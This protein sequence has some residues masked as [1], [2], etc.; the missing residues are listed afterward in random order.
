MDQKLI[1]SLLE[2]PAYP[3]PTAAV[4]LV[5][6]HVS[7]IFI[8]DHFVYKVKKA[9][10]YG[11]LDFT[12][13]DRRRF[14]CGEEVR[15][16]R[17]LCPDVYL[18]VVELRQSGDGAAF[19]GSGKVIDYAVKMKRLPQ[20]RMLDQLLKDGAACAADMARIAAAVASFHAGAD[21]G[22]QIADCGA[23]GVIGENWEQNFRQSAPFVGTTLQGRELAEIRQWVHSFLAAGETLFQSRVTGGFIRDCDGDL[24]S[25][26]ICLTDPVCIFDCIE[27][28]ERFRY[29]DTAADLAFLLM[30]LEYAG[31][32]DLSRELL[33]AYGEASGDLGMAPLLDFYKAQRAFVRGKVTSLRLGQ[34]G[35]SPEESAAVRDAA[36]RYFRL[37]RGYTLRDRLTPTLVLTC[38]LSGSGKSSLAGELG[39]ELGFDLIRSDLVR[40]ALAGVRAS[41]VEPDASYRAGIYS[42]EMDRATYGALLAQAELSLTGGNGIIVDATFQRRSDRER[43]RQLAAR[44]GASCLVLETRCPEA[45]AR[46]RLERRRH[47]PAEVSDARW[48]QYQRQR[49]EFDAPQPG[50]SVLLD[51]T[52]PVWDEAE[53][54][55]AA[56]GLSA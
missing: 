14:Y 48:E 22:P 8:T 51:S 46:E 38:G 23:P 27:F 9:V 39:R 29:I 13:L 37:A 2:A 3:E 33:A 28:N 25:G 49:A 45:V 17:R 19:A 26:N 44:L 11:F 24:H 47:D 55:L 54:V 6:T 56:M 41:G 18:G 34:P 16:N 43:F 36:R 32:P 21:Q 5:E 42:E 12:T 20:E 7:Y 40:K 30:D 52:L 4:R 10:D 50:E 31:R 1:K 35:M 53:R 15:L